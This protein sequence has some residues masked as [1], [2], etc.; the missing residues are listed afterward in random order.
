[1]RRIALGI[2]A[3]CM[4]SFLSYG[5]NCDVTGDG[6]TDVSDVNAIVNSILGLNAN[7]EATDVDGNGITDVSDLNQV[8]DHIL[9]LHYSPSTRQL[10]AKMKTCYSKA[11][12]AWVGEMLSDNTEDNTTH[13]KFDGRY[14]STYYP[15]RHDLTAYFP[16]DDQL[17][18][19]ESVSKRDG[20]DSPLFMWQ[21]NYEAI[22]ACNEVL[23]SIEELEQAGI[24]ANDR[25]AIAALKGEA[26]VS[27][28][29][30]H[31]QLCN[32]F[33]MPYGGPVKSK[34]IAGIPYLTTSHQQDAATTS[35]ESLQDVY[36]LIENDLTAGL[37]LLDNSI[38]TDPKYHFGKQSGNAFASRFYLYKREYDKVVEYSNAAF[39][40]EEPYSLLEDMWHDQEYYDQADSIWRNAWRL[41]DKE[42]IDSVT[43]NQIVDS[44]AL[45]FLNHH[46]GPSRKGVWMVSVPQTEMVQNYRISGKYA[47]NREADVMHTRG[48]AWDKCKVSSN[49]TN[50]II[51]TF[52]G[53]CIAVKDGGTYYGG[54]FMGNCS[55]WVDN[56]SGYRYSL[57]AEFTADQT[58]LNRA[59]AYIHLGKLDLA[60]ADLKAWCDNLCLN[61]AATWDNRVI[62]LTLEDMTK[63]YTTA[64][65]KYVRNVDNE[66]TIRYQDSI[67]SGLAKPIRIDEICPSDKYQV[68]DEAMPY[69]QCVQHFARIETM[70]TG[71][72]WF[73]IKRLG[74]EIRRRCGK[75]N[76][77]IRLESG[78]PRYAVQ[79]R[80]D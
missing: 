17:Y 71:Q 11:G 37:P 29:W 39:A 34:D 70:H 19:W 20:V 6:V 22:A 14:V 60:F 73:D 55:D 31:W 80:D 35:K 12:Y 2:A 43:Y 65:D 54:Y 62:P 76:E 4:A 53:L 57:R 30:H 75:D 48:P 7:G 63:F 36:T 46:S 47:Q 33:C 27:R 45:D 61:P 77:E 72:R 69:L 74:L 44:I 78:D 51:P 10:V 58:L 40:D 64:L 66:V 52:N 50:W 8:I 42:L 41:L 15:E 9:G 25:A 21:G 18:R 13:P 56:E 32:M 26:L 1:M 16:T 67:Y 49:I 23:E 3:I 5:N 68:T 79:M 28:A 24:S 38:H 59:E